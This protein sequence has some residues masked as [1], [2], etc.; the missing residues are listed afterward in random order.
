[1]LA[2]TPFHP[3]A[4]QLQALN[5]VAQWVVQQSYDPKILDHAYDAAQNAIALSDAYFLGH[6]VLGFVYLWQRHYDDAIAEFERAVA[7]DESFVC[8]HMM[9]AYG[10]SHVG[11]LNEA[12]Q[13][14]E[15]ALSLKALLS[16]D[17]CLFGVASA[18]ALAG[19]L[20]EAAALHLR[21]L[22]QFPNFL[23]SYLELAALYS[24]LGREAEAQAAA[25][26]VLR[27]NPQFSLEVH[28]ERS[29]H[30]DPAMLDR[31]IA[32]LRKAGLK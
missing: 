26:E 6:N 28:K 31:H 5:Y 18:Y 14:G 25:A 20:E 30:K 23:V 19:R 32:A 24:E 7:L 4:H 2:L 8:G 9:L 21:M 16:D 17:R 12:V 15:R 22:K 1:M 3:L 10:L 29:P 13:A 11:R 27:I